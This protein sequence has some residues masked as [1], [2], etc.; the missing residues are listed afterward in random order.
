MLQ[1]PLSKAQLPYENT[2]DVSSHYTR[3]MSES[4]HYEI[5]IHP[6]LAFM[7]CIHVYYMYSLY[8]RGP[9]GKDT[10]FDYKLRT[11]FAELMRLFLPLRKTLNSSQ[12]RPRGLLTDDIF[13]K[14]LFQFL[15]FGVITINSLLAFSPRTLQVRLSTGLII[16]LF[17]RYLRGRLCDRRAE[18]CA[19][20]AFILTTP[21]QKCFQL[22]FYVGSQ[23]VCFKL[24]EESTS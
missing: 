24:N 18:L 19:N 7:Q 4:I 22:G 21:A 15:F 13:P 10:T 3:L 14:I 23:E 1:C 5:S 12:P 9:T 2:Y 17:F 16:S 8:I 11:V 6:P 20:S